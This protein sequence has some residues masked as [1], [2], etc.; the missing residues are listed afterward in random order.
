MEKD[1]RDFADY[2]QAELYKLQAECERELRRCRLQSHGSKNQMAPQG[3][4][5]NNSREDREELHRLR[6]E[7]QRLTDELS[8]REQRSS[9]LVSR[10][11]VS[12]QRLQR[13]NADLKVRLDEMERMRVDEWAKFI[14]VDADLTRMLSFLLEQYQLKLAINR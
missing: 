10:L 1:K 4:Q 6:S 8:Q 14:Q 12:L 9:A 11:R 13:E 7:V 3:H 5:A 2:K